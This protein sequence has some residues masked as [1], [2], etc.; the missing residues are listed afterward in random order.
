MKKTKKLTQKQ[1]ENKVKELNA[2]P[3]R[4]PV[5]LDAKKRKAGPHKIKKNKDGEDLANEWLDFFLDDD[6][7]PIEWND[8]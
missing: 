8:E 1:L 2:K 3:Q 6:E 5:A 7:I 4:N